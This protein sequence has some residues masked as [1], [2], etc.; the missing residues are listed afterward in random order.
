M[1]F[2]AVL[3]AV[4]TAAALVVVVALRPPRTEDP[5]IAQL[6]PAAS[7]ANPS[8]TCGSGPCRQLAAMTV[9]GT[10][11]VLYAD[12][13]GGWGRVEI[14][15][16]PSAE[17][18]LAMTSMGAKLNDKSLRCIDGSTPACLIRGDTGGGAY[19]EL[20][21]ATGG[22]WRNFGKPY[23]ADAGTISLYD[24]SQDGRPDVIVVRHECPD[25]T[26]GTPG[27]QAS[28][29]LAEVYELDGAVMGC[30]NTV[31]APSN[32]AGWPDVRLRENQLHPCTS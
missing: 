14:G 21:T 4:V 28:P 23:F 22:V 26:P 16:P 5:G 25:A 17:F 27:C 18:E 2:T 31:T 19:G 13:S 6:V 11:V 30:T 9:G 29:V 24:V 8:A 20:L 7:G 12:A 1:L 15:S 3:A 32:L 10:P